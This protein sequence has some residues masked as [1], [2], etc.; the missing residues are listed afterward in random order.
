MSLFWGNIQQEI[1]GGGMRPSQ[2]VYL[3]QNDL[4]QLDNTG[5]FYPEYNKTLGNRSFTRCGWFKQ[6]IWKGNSPD[7]F[8]D[9]FWGY[10]LEFMYGIR[11]RELSSSIDTIYVHTR[12]SDYANMGPE[13][14]CNFDLEKW[15]FFLITYDNPDINTGIFK[16]YIYDD[17][18]NLIASGTTSTTDNFRTPSGTFNFYLGIPRAI[19]TR[20]TG[21][22]VMNSIGFWD[23]S[24]STSEVQMIYNS[25]NGLSYENLSSELKTNLNAWW[26]CDSINGSN[27][28]DDKHN[29]YHMAGYNSNISLVN[30]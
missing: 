26:D 29:S 8:I 22:V 28:V 13:F 20:G 5:V 14:N 27:G 4:Y 10:S 11:P 15:Y 3:N 1:A 24:V 12:N 2:A 18:N 7:R 6:K 21:I 30:I 23:R 17:L 16:G 25:G 9:F 19:N